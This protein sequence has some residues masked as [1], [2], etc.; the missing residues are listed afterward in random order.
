MLACIFICFIP[1]ALMCFFYYNI[2]ARV[3]RSSRNLARHK[4]AYARQRAAAASSSNKTAGREDNN[5]QL[6]SRVSDLL[7][8]GFEDSPSLFSHL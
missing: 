8:Y 6:K 3:K 4:S 1:V 2:H 7:D 5:E